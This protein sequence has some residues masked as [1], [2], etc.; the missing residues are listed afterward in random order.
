MNSNGV[1]IYNYPKKVAYQLSDNRKA[2]YKK[3]AMRINKDDSIK[4]VSIQHEF[5]LFGGEMGE[6]IVNFLE[7]LNKPKIITFHS[8]LPKP[9]E[10]RL[11][12][13]RKIADN[14]DEIIVMT[15][16]AVKILREKYGLTCPIK[17]IPHGIPTVAFETQRAAKKSLGLEGRLVI[18]SFGMMSVNKGYKHMIQSLPPVVKK[19]PNLLYVIVGATHPNIV[20]HEGERYRNSLVKLVKKLGL[21]RNVKFYNRYAP[22]SEIVQFIKACDVY[23]HS[24]FTPEQITSGTLAYAMGCGRATVS[25]PFLHAQDL[26]N[27]ERGILTKKFRDPESFSEALLEV[28]Q[29]R[30]RLREMEQNAYEHT[31]SM[32]WPNV[33]LAYGDIIKRHITMPEVFFENLPDI[34]MTHVKRMTDNFGMLQFAKYTTPNSSSGYTLDD[35]ARALVV[36]S[37]LYSKTKNKIYLDLVNVYLKYMSFVQEDD[38]KFMNVVGKDKNVVK[39]SWSEE[40][41]GRAIQSLGSVVSQQAIPGEQK[42][43]ARDMLLRALS[44]IDNI[45]APRAISSSIIGLYHYNKEDYSEQVIKI[46]KKFANKLVGLYNENSTPD[47]QWFEH[48]LTYANSKICEALLYSY[49]ITRDKKYLDVAIS[50]LNFLIS[51]T[52]EE[53]VFVPIGQDG[54]FRKGGKRAYFDQQP[55][56]AAAMVK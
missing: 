7:V 46:I 6:Y 9:E 42:K 49:M 51:H 37:K 15:P 23:V 33:A 18:T 34:K 26:I 48:E 25:T 14:I 22:I 32:T 3:M 4:I 20:K 30:K 55:I 28:L 54:W 17:V 56:D 47:W 2:D 38:G 50:S 24:S 44:P 53:G 35:N 10:F 8:V 13:V 52:F 27:S 40:A 43:E 11:N 12:L 21:E 41:H 16:K 36:A 29:D 31:R 5:G 45:N 19:Y 39:D 1:N